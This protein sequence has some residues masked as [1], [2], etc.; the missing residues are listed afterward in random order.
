MAG[1]LLQQ[2]C[3]CMLPVSCEIAVQSHD[4]ERICKENQQFLQLTGGKVDT[5][6]QAKRKGVQT[7]HGARMEAAGPVLT[8]QPSR[9]SKKVIIRFTHAHRTPLSPGPPAPEVSV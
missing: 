3:A 1:Y 4:R 7:A 9:L 5:R 2:V 8:R 6:L